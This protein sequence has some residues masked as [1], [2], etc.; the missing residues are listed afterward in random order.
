MYVCNQSDYIQNNNSD[1][2]PPNRY[3][4][5]SEA[6]RLGGCTAAFVFAAPRATHTVPRQSTHT[7]KTDVY[8]SAAACDHSSAGTS[9][10]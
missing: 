3:R 10:R 6:G 9:G 8:T 2:R 4:G 1:D 7:H 5:G